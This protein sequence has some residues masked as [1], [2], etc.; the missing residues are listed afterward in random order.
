MNLETP[1]AGGEFGTPAEVFG[2]RQVYDTYVSGWI[3][4][5]LNVL[6]RTFNLSK[7]KTDSFV[8]F[9]TNAFGGICIVGQ[10]EQ[11]RETIGFA[12]TLRGDKVGK[13]FVFA[14][15]PEG[16]FTIEKIKG[17]ERLRQMPRHWKI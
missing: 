10:I 6:K 9:R 12:T 17:E 7:F 11:G 14:E 2:D 3:E 5:R 16:L 8:I 4:T 15:L 1:S 13:I